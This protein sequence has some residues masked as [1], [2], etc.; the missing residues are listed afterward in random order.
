MLDYK[1]IL[2]LRFASNFSGREI[3]KSCGYSKS[4]VNEFLKRFSK[5]GSLS[6]PIGPEVTNEAIEELLYRKRGIQSNDTESLYRQPDYENLYKS[7][8]KKG[9]TLKRQWRKYNAI[10]IVDEMKPY[11]Y[12]QYCQ[13]FS[14]WLD[15]KKI[16]YHIVRYPGVNLELDFAGKV[17]YLCNKYNPDA[18][19]KVTIFMSTLSYS[20]YFYAEGMTCCNSRNWTRVNNNALRFFGGVT[21]ICTPDNTKVAV[22]KNMD[23]IDPLLN[24]DFQEWAAYYGTAIMPAV[25]RGPTF[26]PN[27]EAS[28]GFVTR[29]ILMD[30]EEMTFFSLDALNEVLWEKIDE[31]NKQNFQGRDY[32]RRDLFEREERDLLLPL[33]PSDYQFLERQQVT[34]YQD[35]SFVFDH[36]HY[37][38][39]RKFIKHSLNIRASATEVY[40]YTLKDDLFRQYK[41][42]HTP[43]EWV[44]HPG[45]LPR[46]ATDYDKWSVPFF[47]NW[48]SGVGPNTRIV[49]DAMLAQVPYP[50]QAFRRCMGVLGYAKRKGKP[51]LEACCTNAAKEGKCN[52]NYIKNTIADYELPDLVESSTIDAGETTATVPVVDFYKVDGSHYSIDAILARQ[53]QEGGNNG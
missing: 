15:E 36:V 41:R 5:C 33:P 18:R 49:I 13:K 27:V 50:V 26:K 34:V 2:G 46:H 38:M 14:Q 25:V 51:V 32:S 11:S 22:L 4:A 23:W 37:T 39:P 28:V 31:L 53:E 8:A 1:R 44:I 48:A 43:G 3:A 9:E 19:M 12:R 30:M 20:K 10:G 40:V 21:Q 52:Y 17:L 7:L 45:D 35:F 6:L 47:Q 16:T 29:N 24:K 42:C